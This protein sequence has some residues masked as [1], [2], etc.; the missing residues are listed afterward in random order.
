MDAPTEQPAPLDRGKQ[1]PRRW[2]ART[3]RDDSK[4]EV[5]QAG[6]AGGWP[7]VCCSRAIRLGPTRN[8]LSTQNRRREKVSNERVRE[9]DSPK[10]KPLGLSLAGSSSLCLHRE[11]AWVPPARSAVLGEPMDL[12]HAGRSSYFPGCV[13]VSVEA[14]LACCDVGCCGRYL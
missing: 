9:I 4:G 1:I 5:G 11:Y 7:T 14:R 8:L 2:P 10:P 3:P 12:R 6:Q 13:W